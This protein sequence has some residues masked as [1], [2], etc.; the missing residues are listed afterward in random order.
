[1]P[2]WIVS[3]LAVFAFLLSASVP[4]AK[5]G[6]GGGGGPLPVLTKRPA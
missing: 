5:S 1:M 2:R 3:V 4:A 6:G